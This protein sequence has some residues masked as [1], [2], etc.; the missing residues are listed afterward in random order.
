MI[1]WELDFTLSGWRWPLLCNQKCI[2]NMCLQ[3]VVQGFAL[4]SKW[5]S[6]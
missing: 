4:H 2:C 3:E 5:N 6:T 1:L